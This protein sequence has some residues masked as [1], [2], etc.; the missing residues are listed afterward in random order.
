MTLASKPERSARVVVVSYFHP[1]FPGAGGNRWDAMSHYLRALRYTVTIIACDAWGALPTDS[2]LGVRRVSDLRSVGVLRRALGRGEMQVAGAGGS[3]S[4][5]RP[6][7]P[8]LT[9]VVAPDPH[10]ASWDPAVLRM[11]AGMIRR[12]LVD[13]LVTTGPPASVHLLGLALGRVRP[14]WVADFRDGWRFDD[15]REPFPTAMQRGLDGWMERRVVRTADA[16]VGATAPI[17]EDLGARLGGR[18]RCVPNA[19]DPRLIPTELPAS[20]Q[21]VLDATTLVSVGTLSGSR[22]R[23]PRPL[24]R[25]LGEVGSGS[26]PIRIRLVHAGRLTTEE[27]ALIED[28]G[29]ADLVQHLGTVTRGEA[30]ALQRSADALV[31]LTSRNP[32]EAASKTFEY[33]AAGRPILALAEGNEAARIVR[34]TNAGVTVAPDDVDSIAGALRRVASGES[35][36]TYAPR[37]LDRFTYPAPADAMADVIEDALRRRDASRRRHRDV[38]GQRRS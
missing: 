27:R 5:E 4:V 15:G 9:Q 24:L 31:L 18:A 8:L 33:L 30:L 10:L 23:D 25:A 7:T 32:S 16:V 26:D 2:A 6:P 28:L 17:A 36:R 38:T 35:A 13:C 37:G 3:E 11:L 22:G 14:A 29:V 1:P 19:W 20:F 21:P 12:E 34:E